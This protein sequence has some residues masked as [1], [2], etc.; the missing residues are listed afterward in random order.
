MWQYR[1]TNIEQN[2][3]EIGEE[4][5]DRS[6]IRRTMFMGITTLLTVTYSTASTPFLALRVSSSSFLH[7]LCKDEGE[8]YPLA[9]DVI[10]CH[11]YVDDC[12][13][14]ADTESVVIQIRE[15]L[16]AL[17][18][19]ARFQLSKWA[20]N[21]IALLPDHLAE[22]DG[23]TH[24][25]SLT[26][27]DSHKVLGIAWQ[28]TSD[29][30]RFQIAPPENHIVTNRSILS[31]IAKLYD[32]LGWV[33][34]VVVGAKIL[35]HQLWLLKRGWDDSL[36]SDIRSQWDRF[37]EQLSSLN[38]ISISRY[39]HFAPTIRD[40]QLHGFADASSLA[41][42]AVVYQ[43]VTTNDGRVTLAL[44]VAKTEVAPVKTVATSTTI[45]PSITLGSGAQWNKPTYFLDM[46]LNIKFWSIA[47]SRNILL[48][49]TLNFMTLSFTQ[50]PFLSDEK[51]V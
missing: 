25:K 15:Q 21:S 34:P 26:E 20:S 1:T 51:N 22:S 40:C 23:T 5:G 45:P 46:G 37:Q 49:S 36:P 13:F 4:I 41:Y 2:F 6:V 10:R 11:T 29:S 35:L 32:P 47:R 9:V 28:S 24:H 30:F 43:R 18:A 16:I 14:G 7:Q 38:H 19:S 12:I 31:I 8:N 33:A 17:L 48:K 3:K 42:A 44:F 27:S 50:M 39:T